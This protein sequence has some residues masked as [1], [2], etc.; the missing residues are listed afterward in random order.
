MTTAIPDGA[1]VVATRSHGQALALP[2]LLVVDVIE[3]YL[4]EQGIGEGPIAWERIGDG[5]S[6]IT[7]LIERGST[8]F[9]LRRGPRPPLPKSTHDMVREARIL[10]LLG[11]AGVRVPRIFSICEDE[12]LLGVPFYIMEFI[13]GHV[14]TDSVPSYLGSIEQRR[15][16]VFAAVDALVEL[17]RVDVTTGDLAKIGR[18]HGYLERQVAR[19]RSLWGQSSTRA[20]PEIDELG[21]WLAD[22]VPESQAASVVHGDYRLGNIVFELSAPAQVAAILD[23]EMA[24]IGD[25]LTDLGY[26]TA[27][28]AVNGE[29][30]T[31]MELSPVTREASYP[32]REEV[33]ERYSQQLPFSLEAL[34]WYQALALW[35]A[36]IFCE[37][38][39]ARWLNGE[40][41]GDEFGPTLA[42][43]VPTL[44]RAATRFAT[45]MG[46]SSEAGAP[47]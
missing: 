16:T 19:F 32:T 4:E 14:I 24:T 42:E 47:T 6:N 37:A 22:N 21:A 25:P 1:E 12:A 33:I 28:Y 23:W 5:Q 26:L 39:Y 31:P 43:G 7:F 36:A 17:H 27:T 41:Q 45:L 35:K 30:R 18:P 29:L 34:P 2:P 20:L 46:S 11:E 9:V 8:K 44:A 10:G 13:E 38:I 40:R 15:A 3:D